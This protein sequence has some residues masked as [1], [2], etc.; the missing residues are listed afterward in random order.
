MGPC[1]SLPG[2]TKSA[3]CATRNGAR[4]VTETEPLLAYVRSY[5]AGLSEDQEEAVRRQIDDEL[6]SHG[7]FNIT[8]DSGLLSGV[9]R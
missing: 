3:W 8:K 2:S 4:I 6:A 5:V 7:A 1:N 9:K